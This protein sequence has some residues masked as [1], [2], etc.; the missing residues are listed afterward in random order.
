M[1]FLLLAG[2][3]LLVAGCGFTNTK[4]QVQTETVTVTRTVTHTVTSASPAPAATSGCAAADLAATFTVVAGSA[5][6]GNIVYALRVTNTSSAPCFV[7]GIPEAQLLDASGNKLETSGTPNGAG[8]AVKTVLQPNSSATADARFS[9]DVDPCGKTPAASLQV[10]TPGGGTLDVKIEP[11]T[12]VCN[13]G[14]IQ[15]SPFAT[16]S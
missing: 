10:T 14:A 7:S 6:A 9:P 13:H 4:T 1:R 5:G 12:R 11:A 8:T 3:S 15:W 16:T 2:A